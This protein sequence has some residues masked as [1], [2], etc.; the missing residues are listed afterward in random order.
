MNRS[1]ASLI[2]LM[3]CLPGPWGCEPGTLGPSA[4]TGTTP[5]G[6]ST[7]STDTG[8]QTPGA[9][10]GS[11]STTPSIPAEPPELVDLRADVNRNGTVDLD[12]PTE[13]LGEES[14]D[15]MH[16]AIFLA[17]LD[18]DR[19]ACPKTGSDVDLPKCHD[20]A[21]EVVNGTDDLLDLARLKIKPWPEA[22][23]QATGKIAVN[24]KASPYVRLFVAD[25]GSFKVLQPATY[26]FTATQL[27]AGVE[28]AVEGKDVVRDSAVWDG[29]A[30]ITLTV[31]GIPQTGSLSDTVRMR[32]APLITRHHLDLP[33]IVYASYAAGDADS[34][35][36]VRDLQ[37]AMTAAQIQNPL[38]KLPIQDQWTQD[39]FE[40]AYMAMPA[41]GGLHA[42]HV[43]I[44]SA[45]VDEPTNTKNP[46]RPGGQVVFT[47]LRGKDVAG[48]SQYDLK[49]PGNMDTLDSFGNTETIPP[50]SVNGKSYPLGRIYRGKTASYYP[51]VK[52]SALFE[53][54]KVQPPVYVDTSW[55][56]VGH[57]DETVTFVKASNARGWT[58]AVN[59]ARLAK[60]MLEEQ[61]KAGNGSVVMFKGLTWDSYGSQGSSAETSISA[62]LADADVMAASARA[63]VEV[64][65]QVAVLKATVGIQDVEI[66][67]LPYLHYE[68]DGGSVAYQV[69]TINGISLGDSHFGSPKPHGPVIG[70]RDIMEVQMEA[71]FGKVG[72]QVH[73]I[74]N[75]NLYHRLMGEVHCGSNT[76]RKI[77]AN[78]RWWESGL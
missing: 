21:D 55:L 4:A 30:D 60:S 45:N 15:A 10:P 20:A 48:I 32:L 31:Q 59:D 43:N 64:D 53:S 8:G 51:D 50:Y 29:F 25:Q 18:D 77:P 76:T 70:G 9:A 2:I 52:M 33:E 75:W 16:G 57:V 46:L 78:V 67:H 22:P 28:L 69:G 42:I 44:R 58:I 65:N 12:D 47:Q 61:V 66:L 72:I 41:V 63:A 3:F 14:W 24:D 39:L 11:D 13:N 37:T 23:D 19:A 7:S 26:L 62:V 5:G 74:E 35:A 38:V 49:H 27:R 17:N 68:V 6:A 73:W 40:T 56:L 1:A 54:Q 34:E 71:E 36:L